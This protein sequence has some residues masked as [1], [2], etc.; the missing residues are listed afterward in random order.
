MTESGIAAL[1]LAD[2]ATEIVRFDIELGQPAREGAGCL[3]E[4]MS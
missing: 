2:E 4:M 1:K 3:A